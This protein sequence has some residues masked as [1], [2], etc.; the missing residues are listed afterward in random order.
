[1]KAGIILSMLVLSI[2]LVLA[3]CRGPET[4]GA[5]TGEQ[6]DWWPT[7]AQPQPVDDPRANAMGRWWWPTDPGQESSPLWGNRG[8]VYVLKWSKTGAE[9]PVELKE[10]EALELREV[11]F[12]FDK[13]ELTPAAKEILTTAI[14]KLKSFPNAHVT[15][16]GH[17]CSIGDPDYN[18]GLGERR[19]KSVMSFLISQG[20]SSERLSVKSYGETM[21]KVPERKASDYA[22]NRRVEF[23][24]EMR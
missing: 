12:A 23:A 21:L 1:M 9:V 4:T 7:Q 11:H 24:I 20:I 2:M 10:I 3:G 16:E 6:L 8:Y 13:S 19:A 15:I 22:Q 14:G 5:T 17:T 18:M